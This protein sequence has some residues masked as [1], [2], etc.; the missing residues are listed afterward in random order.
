MLATAAAFGLRPAYTTPNVE[1][2]RTNVASRRQAFVVVSMIQAH[3]TGLRITLD[4]DDCERILR[5]QDC[6]TTRPLPT[7][8]IQRLVSALG[9]AIE[10]LAD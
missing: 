10:P 4:L 8:A 3:F 2:F 7:A 6:H 5:V 9:F 1:I